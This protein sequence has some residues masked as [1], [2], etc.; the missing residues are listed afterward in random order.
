ME[1][2]RK[3]FQGVLNI[4]RF[5]WHFYAVAGVVIFTLIFFK[6]ILPQQLQYVILAAIIMTILNIIISLSV[7]F[8]I[9]DV[10]DLYKL[11]WLPD[12]NKKQVLTI[13]AGFDETS[14]LII[15]K[16]PLT[17]LTICDFYNSKKHTEVSIE[18]ARKAY[19]PAAKTMQVVTDSL[20]FPDN[21][22]DYSFTILA[23]HEIRNENERVQF[24]KELSRVTKITGYIYVTEHLRD[25]NNFMAYS[26]G[27]FH[28]HSKPTWL[29]TFEKA[30]LSFYKDIK[31]TPF[32]TTFILS[33]N[34]NSL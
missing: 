18:R 21:S 4:I 34:E 2:K 20:P 1:I 5:N 16:F 27:F 17:E 7:S 15:N 28:F 29:R 33:Q 12:T 31:V 3:P 10:S 24:F 30:N 22:F 13:N 25:L 19:P 11:K 23:A 9:Y 14:D 6:E 8:Y 32:V 26:I